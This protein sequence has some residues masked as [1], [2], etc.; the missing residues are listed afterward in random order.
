MSPMQ[1][2]KV[3][4]MMIAMR[5]LGTTDHIMALGWVEPASVTS[6]AVQIV[7]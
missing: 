1:K 4:P 7:G 2:T 6:S 3:A 5:P